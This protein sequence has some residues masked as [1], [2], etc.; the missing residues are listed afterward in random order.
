MLYNTIYCNINDKDKFNFVREITMLELLLIL[1]IILA[2]ICVIGIILG[3]RHNNRKL[4]I[5][6]TVLLCVIIATCVGFALFIYWL[7]SNWNYN[8][9]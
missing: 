7:F 8:F 6:F 9:F 3:K 1:A 4:T 2:V 5:L